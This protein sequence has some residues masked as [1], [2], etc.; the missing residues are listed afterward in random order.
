TEK[1]SGKKADIK[2]TNS[3]GLDKSEIEKM[4]ADAAAHAEEDKRRREL[5]ETKNRAE[6]MVHQTRK[7]LEEHGEKVS[8]DVRGRIEGALSNVEDKLKGDDKS[9]IEAALK[10]LES[11]AM[12][13]GRVIYEAEAA[14]GAGAGAAGGAE[15]A[16]GEAGGAGEDDVIDAEYEVKEEKE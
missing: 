10:E 12:E 15:A 13:L 5:V 9:A 3:G 8:G 4:Q 2:I 11:S 16:A 7:S 1:S 6:S 14:K